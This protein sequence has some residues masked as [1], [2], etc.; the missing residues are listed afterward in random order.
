M[1]S[2]EEVIHVAKLARLKL[3]EEEIEKYQRELS[4]ILNYI[5]KLKKVDISKVSPTS[6][7]ILIKEAM[8]QDKEEEFPREKKIFLLRMAPQLK[9]N[10]IKVKKII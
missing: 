9:E 5:E 4:K 1:I 8:R 6:H 7:S 2:K 10:F 3:S